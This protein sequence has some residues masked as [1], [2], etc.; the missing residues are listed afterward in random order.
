MN[1][2][3]G[4]DAVRNA[5]AKLRAIGPDMI[6]RTTAIVGFPGEQEEDFYELC[7]FIEETKFDRFGAF[8][9]SRE[10]GTPAA[11]FP[12]QTDEQTKQDR[13]DKIMQLQ[14]EINEELNEKRSVRPSKFFT[15][16]GTPSPKAATAAVTPTRRKSTEKSTSRRNAAR[17]RAISSG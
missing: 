6:I 4:E 3:G 10:E 12:D 5:V 7:D 17:K 16:A 1:R 9:Y 8:A 15:R 14:Y 13:L 11:D 2:H